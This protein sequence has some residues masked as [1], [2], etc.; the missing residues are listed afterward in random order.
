VDLP[1]RRRNASR[2]PFKIYWGCGLTWGRGRGT[3]GS[4][5]NLARALL[6]H[7]LLAVLALLPGP[8]DA[9]LDLELAAGAY[10]VGIHATV[11]VSI[12][13]AAAIG[14]APLGG[15]HA[16]LPAPLALEGGRPAPLLFF[17]AA[18]EVPA[19]LRAAALEGHAAAAFTLEATAA[20]ATLEAAAATATLE[21]AA[22]TALQVP[23]LERVGVGLSK[24]GDAE[25]GE[26]SRRG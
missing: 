6:H 17:A 25:Q 16:L 14:P 11:Q 2:G 15:L 26:M 5:Q 12:A 8:A 7:A 4:R 9:L 19:P 20:T 3:S 18:L 13:A 22:A 24:D 21:A 1:R 23:G 10:V